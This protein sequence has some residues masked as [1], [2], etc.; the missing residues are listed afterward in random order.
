[1]TNTTS[2]HVA[3]H[4]TFTAPTAAFES[5]MHH[6]RAYLVRRLLAIYEGCQ[7]HGG[8]G[9]KRTHWRGYVKADLAIIVADAY[10]AFPISNE[11]VA[12]SK[13]VTS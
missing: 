9:D 4:G 8:K 7:A 3:G 10:G 6:S 12:A 1:M 5:R 11:S 13:G 2:R